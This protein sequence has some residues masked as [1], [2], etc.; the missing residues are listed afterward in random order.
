MLRAQIM[1]A[2]ASLL[3]LRALV[4]QRTP[5]VVWLHSH[6]REK[7]T[8]VPSSCPRG[9][10]R[11]FQG[12]IA[13]LTASQRA[14][15]KRSQQPKP[16]L[17]DEKNALRPLMWSPWVGVWVK[18]APAATPSFLLGKS[19][20]GQ[21]RCKAPLKANPL[22]TCPAVETLPRFRWVLFRLNTREG[23]PGVAYTLHVHPRQ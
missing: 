1:N 17:R 2:P 22:P 3:L 23:I 21:Y 7:H 18:K 20:P 14:T 4:S 6:G 9:R 10:F 16:G 8:F 5:A 19:A 12:T 11:R 15:A 13:Q